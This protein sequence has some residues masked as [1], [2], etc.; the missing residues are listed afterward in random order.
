M[1]IIRKTLQ[2]AVI[3]VVAFVAMSVLALA[4]GTTA[5]AD[6]ISNCHN[7]FGG[8]ICWVQVD[9]WSYWFSGANDHWQFF[10]G[11]SVS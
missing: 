4:F 5:E 3:A 11:W 2:A 10:S 8:A 6:S 9:W 1:R 7:V